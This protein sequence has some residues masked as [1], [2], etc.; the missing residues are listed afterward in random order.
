MS[1]RITIVKERNQAYW[2]SLMSDVELWL[3]SPMA[4]HVKQFIE[5]A[6]TVLKALAVF[7]EAEKEI[8][9]WRWVDKDSGWKA[10]LDFVDFQ[11]SVIVTLSAQWDWLHKVLCHNHPDSPYAEELREYQKMVSTYYHRLRQALPDNAHDHT[12]PTAP[13]VCFGDVPSLFR[14]KRNA[15][16]ILS[17]PLNSR[18]DPRFKDTIPHEISHALFDLIPGFL[19]EMTLHLTATL[20]KQL[21]KKHWG[22]KQT[23]LNKLAL[24]MLSEIVAELVAIALPTQAENPDPGQNVERF[25]QFMKNTIWLSATTGDE[26]GIAPRPFALIPYIRLKAAEHAML[27]RYPSEHQGNYPLTMDI[28]KELKIQVDETMKELLNRRFEAIPALTLLS[29]QELRDELDNN[30]IPQILDAKLNSLGKKPFGMILY[31]CACDP[32][33]HEPDEDSD[34]GAISGDELEQFVLALPA[35]KDRG[36]IISETSISYGCNDYPSCW[37]WPCKGCPR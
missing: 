28:I 10:E 22:R 8:P 2:K 20:T 33:L 17:I 12:S 9:I 19:P 30:V 1:S 27:G 14:F 5:Y 3:D 29:L 6:Y 15:P 16:S 11:L 21:A 4:H 7:N 32:E 26:A 34:W 13:L 18:I 23:I 36:A 35:S 25:K 37:Y 31:E 24:N